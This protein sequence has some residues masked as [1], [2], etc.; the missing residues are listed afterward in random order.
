MTAVA[1]GAAVFAESIDWKSQSRGRKSSRGALS[2]GGAI[3]LAFNY[4]TFDFNQPNFYLNFAR[5]RNLYRLSVQDYPMFRDFYVSY[6]RY[7]HEQV[8]NLDAGRKNRLF[9]FLQNNALPENRSYFYDYFYDNCSTRPRD[10][11]KAVLGDSVVFNADP[12]YLE[13][14]SIRDL[15]DLYLRQQPWGDLGID[16][17]LGLPM[18][19]TASA[20]EYM[21]LPDYLETGFDLATLTTSTGKQPLV[22][23]K[24]IVYEQQPE[25][26]PFPLTHPWVLF[27]ALLLVTGW[28]TWRKITAAEIW[29]DRGLFIITGVVGLLLV[30]LW[31]LTDHKA[32]AWN[33]NLLWAMPLNLVFT[34]RSGDTRKTYFTGMTFLT[35]VLL[36]SW[37]F[38]P[39]QLNPFLIPL[40]AALGIRYWANSR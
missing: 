19:K 22:L 5:G 28:V 14:Y 38:L 15:T 11:I 40:A 12:P 2:T 17:C 18:D 24:S 1:E 23:E 37:A 32:A 25:Q 9:A 35:A 39:Q 33:F 36:V 3:D 10:V 4:G 20:T 30:L 27:G 7:I 21:F 31:F 13:G 26:Q 8:L 16:I 34:F 6:N 29:M